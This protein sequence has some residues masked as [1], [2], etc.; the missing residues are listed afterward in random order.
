MS[1]KN[2]IYQHFTQEELRIKKFVYL[3]LIN[4]EN[5]KENVENV[6]SGTVNLTFEPV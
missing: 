6:F 2:R 4:F 5:I 3:L 1:R